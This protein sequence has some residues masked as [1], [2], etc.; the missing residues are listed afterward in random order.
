MV[1]FISTRAPE[2]KAPDGSVIVPRMAARSWPY[3]GAVS[4]SAAMNVKK[5]QFS[6]LLS[7]F[8]SAY[9]TNKLPADHKYRESRTRITAN[10]QVAGVG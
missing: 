4:N 9:R 2:T 1:D 3:N 7:P 5:A 8:V 6:F 10:F